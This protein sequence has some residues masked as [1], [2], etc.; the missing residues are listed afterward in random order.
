MEIVD[1]DSGEHQRGF[2]RRR[3]DALIEKVAEIAQ[4][5]CN[6]IDCAKIAVWVRLLVK[7][8]GDGTE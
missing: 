6:C 3:T 1:F 4:V 8:E 2:E 7:H 5:D